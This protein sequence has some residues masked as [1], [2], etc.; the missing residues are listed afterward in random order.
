MSSCYKM[1]L[2]HGTVRLFVGSAIITTVT[3][4]YYQHLH[5]SEA[6]IMRQHSVTSFSAEE[7]EFHEE[8]NKYLVTPSVRTSQ[9]ERFSPLPQQ[10]IDHVEKFVFF[11]GY[12]RSGH[13]IVSSV[14]SHYLCF[15][16]V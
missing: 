1:V 5:F 10:V 13:T 3:V 6:Q 7:G 14:L 16:E 8:Q 2:K 4:L 15:S 9:L 12:T 11:I